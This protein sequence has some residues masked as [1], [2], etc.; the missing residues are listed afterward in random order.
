MYYTAADVP[1]PQSSVTIEHSFQNA[2]KN[3]VSVFPGKKNFS[4]RELTGRARSNS[5]M[6]NE[7]GVN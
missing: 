2:G 1:R 4:F 6:P 3:S 5:I 7:N